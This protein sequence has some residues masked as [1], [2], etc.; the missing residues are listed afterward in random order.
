MQPNMAT[1]R[2]KVQLSIISPIGYA[3]SSCGYCTAPG[4]GKRSQR[5]SSQSYGIWAHRL[6]PY[7]YQSLIDQGWRRSGDYIYKPDVLRTCCAQIPIRLAVAD[8]KPKKGHKRALTNL[9]FRVRSS[10]P[11][12]AKWKGRW[13]RGRDWNVEHRLNEVL[14]T[15]DNQAEA[16]TSS[17]AWAEQVAGPITSKLQVRLALAGTSDEKYQLFR[18]Y[19][20][21]VH[22]ESEDDISSEKGF[23][24]FLVD[25]SLSLTW[26]S[27]GEPLNESQETQWRAKSFDLAQLPDELPYGN[28][29]QE[30][31]LDG[32]LIAVGVL[33]ILPK[34]VSSVYVFYD[35]EYNDWELGKVSALQ[36][37]ALTK[38][39]GRLKGMEDTAY[40]YMGF[41]IHTCQKMKYKAEYRPSELLDCS[42]N[43]WRKTVDIGASLDAKQYFGWSNSEQQPRQNVAASQELDQPSKGTEEGPVRVPTHP[44][45]PPGMLDAQ[46]ILQ[47]LE[48]T[49]G[50]SEPTELLSG[51]DLLQQAMVLEAQKQAEGIKPL[52]ISNIFRDY[53]QG[54]RE[55]N[56]AEE[57][58]ELVQVVECIA[59]LA[60]GE[61]VSQMVLFM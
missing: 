2:T 23:C 21:K 27:T 18:K 49:L 31:R 14:S 32:K 53:V 51:L 29:H 59:A 46:A 9:L 8:L 42:D 57:D 60:S 48:Q 50:G 22:G 36:E 44:S 37:I 52:L 24:R 40:Y 11:K 20:A 3:T 10:K 47:A 1:K 30:Y 6:S 33:D 38:R 4:S 45:P 61:L 19:Q 26:P 25:S 15:A 17:S 5:K 56:E 34:C 54:R 43:S 12:P 55:G 13:S 39:L 7:H 16:S 58:S 28:Y 41:Y 35:P